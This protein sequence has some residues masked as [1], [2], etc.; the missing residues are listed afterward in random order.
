MIHLK[1][2]REKSLRRR[3]PWIFS[4]AIER[5]TETPGSGDTVEVRDASG[6]AWALA[7]Y[8]PQ[9]QIRARVWTFDTTQE[10]DAAFFR[11]RVMRAL[12][13]REALPAAKHSNAL[14]L[15]HGESDGLPG[16]IVDRYGDAISM[17][18]LTAGMERHRDVILQSLDELLHPATVATV[19]ATL[20]PGEVGT[21]VS[22]LATPA[23]V[24]TTTAE[25]TNLVS[26][27]QIGS[28]GGVTIIPHLQDFVV[29][30]PFNPTGVSETSS[31]R[32]FGP[33][34]SPAVKTR[35]CSDWAWR[36][37]T[38]SRRSPSAA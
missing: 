31:R 19:N 2:G 22:V 17:Q 32:R 9:S 14:R 25:T 21:S 27:T 23:E 12:A 38:S 8:S 28:Q 5:L 29:R 34:Q 35:W 7:A 4:G 33:P 13:L 18:L 3:H 15:V 36:K 1:A 6:K 11:A 37:R 10:V 30:G 26:D 20:T 24:Q 16:L